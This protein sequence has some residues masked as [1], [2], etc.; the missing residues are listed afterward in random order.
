MVAVG[1]GGPG[2]VAGG[3]G[4]GYVKWK[5]RPGIQGYLAIEVDVRRSWRGS[6]VI[7][8][9]GKTLLEAKEGNGTNQFKGGS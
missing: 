6:I 9:G 2:G 4:S 1:G 3:G 8:E 5:E 7:G